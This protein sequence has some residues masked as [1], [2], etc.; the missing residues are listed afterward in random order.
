MC[1]VSHANAVFFLLKVPSEVMTCVLPVTGLGS[2]GACGH[3]HHI[4]G[5]TVLI[6][7]TFAAANKMGMLVMQA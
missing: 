4:W 5:V 7:D 6:P 1:P 2:A 3:S